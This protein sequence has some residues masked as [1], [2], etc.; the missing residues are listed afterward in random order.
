[1]QN[2]FFSVVQV[3]SKRRSF[4]SRRRMIPVLQLQDN[5]D[6]RVVEFDAVTTK[7]AAKSLEKQKVKLNTQNHGPAT[8]LDETIA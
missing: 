3:P 8:V 7:K 1:M 2:Y 6:T 4:E 5:G